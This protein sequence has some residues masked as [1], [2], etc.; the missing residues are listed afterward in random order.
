MIYMHIIIFERKIMLKIALL[1]L[2]LFLYE[3][4][5]YPNVFYIKK[6]TVSVIDINGCRCF[7]IISFS[8]RLYRKRIVANCS[9]F[10][11]HW[12]HLY[13]PSYFLDNVLLL[14]CITSTFSMCSYQCRS[15]ASVV[16]S[17]KAFKTSLL[18]QLERKA[19]FWNN[20]FCYFCL[21]NFSMYLHT[22]HWVLCLLS[23]QWLWVFR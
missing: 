6:Q 15:E 5:L 22:R 9:F 2:L 20:S 18:N 3:R 4:K 8:V 10:R 21:F 7:E 17:T 23:G 12:S 19:L 13:Y 16:F 11:N 14:N 1:L